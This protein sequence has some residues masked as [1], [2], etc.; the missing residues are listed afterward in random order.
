MFQMEILYRYNFCWFRCDY[1]NYGTERI[2]IDADGSFLKGT[3]TARTNSGVVPRFQIKVE[4]VLM[5][6]LFQ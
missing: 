4:V 2:R 6:P 1:C 5:K 3:T